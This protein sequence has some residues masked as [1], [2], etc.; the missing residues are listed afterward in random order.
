R[1]LLFRRTLSAKLK[2]FVKLTRKNT[3]WCWFKQ[4]QDAFDDLKH[5]ICSPPTLKY[6]YVQKPVTLICDASQFGLGAACLQ[7][8]A[9]VAY[10]S[11][12]QTQTEVHYAQIEKELL[13]VVFACTKFNDYICGKQI[14]IETDHQPLVTNHNKPIYTAPAKLQHMML[15][16]R[17]TT[18]QS[19]TRKGKDIPCRHT[20]HS[21]RACTNELYDDPADIEAMSI[22]HILSSRLKDLQT[23][24]A[25]DPALQSLCSILKSG[26]P[27]SQSKL[28]LE[29]HEYFPFRDELTVD[30]DVLMK[31]QRIVVPTQ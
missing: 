24:A 2:C 6:Y 5:K 26:W 16:C 28:P 11:R 10:A 25:L 29:I 1:T 22:W 23:C 8:G 31:G 12:T 7:E 20:L 4:H 9:P 3:E 19:H 13:A 30:E 15:R 21:P 27:S 14:Y 18:S 17:N